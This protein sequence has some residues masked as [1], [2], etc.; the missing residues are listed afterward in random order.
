MPSRQSWCAGWR[1]KIEARTI[2]EGNFTRHPP[3]MAHFAQE[4]KMIFDIL[5]RAA[6]TSLLQHTRPILPTSIQDLPESERPSPPPSPCEEIV[7]IGERT[8]AFRV[9]K[10]SPR[11]VAPAQPPLPTGPDL[12]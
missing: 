3:T 10:P 6:A 5:R 12:V 2:V 9:A 4:T 1:G 8:E 11:V 7:V